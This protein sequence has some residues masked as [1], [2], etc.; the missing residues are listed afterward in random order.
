MVSSTG[1]ITHWAGW[2]PGCRCTMRWVK[3]WSMGCIRC[4]SRTWCVLALLQRLLLHRGL[5]GTQGLYEDFG[6]PSRCR[7][8][9]PDPATRPWGGPTQA[10]GCIQ[11]SA[12]PGTGTP[13]CGRYCSTTVL[14]VSIPRRKSCDPGPRRSAA[15]R[16][17]STSPAPPHQRRGQQRLS[18]IRR[19]PRRECA[20]QTR[21]GRE[22][23]TPT[24][25]TPTA[26]RGLDHHFD[27]AWHPGI[28]GTGWRS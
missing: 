15:S 3:A 8:R 7:H 9:P 18:Q 16:R 10:L 2:F 14:N 26:A 25:T 24:A 11:P 6:A 21:P 13:M 1:R 19:H 4:W 28:M 22:R 27:E 5:G 20:P 17:S 12:A 23:H